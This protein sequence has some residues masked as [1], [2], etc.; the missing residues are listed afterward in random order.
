LKG[1]ITVFFGSAYFIG[2]PFSGAGVGD[3]QD[4]LK[5]RRLVRDVK[6]AVEPKLS[7][8]EEREG[9]TGAAEICAMIPLSSRDML[10]GKLG[11]Y[12]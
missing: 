12:D 8:L 4:Q 10:F 2:P 11:L 6:I 9:G 7:H 5:S 1:I 3:L